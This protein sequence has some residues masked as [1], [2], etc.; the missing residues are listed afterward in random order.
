MSCLRTKCQLTLKNVVDCVGGWLKENPASI[1]AVCVVLSL[2]FTIYVWV[3]ANRLSKPWQRPIL[4]VQGTQ[5]SHKEVD[6]NGD[7]TYS[8]IIKWRNIGR[9]PATDIRTRCWGA[10]LIAPEELQIIGDNNIAN[11]I[12]PEMGWA[13]E[14][15]FKNHGVEPSHINDWSAYFLCVRVDFGDAFEPRRRDHRILYFKYGEKSKNL[16]HATQAEKCRFELY[17]GVAG[18]YDH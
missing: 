1:S 5:C 13:K 3:Q 18:V 10:R 7:V 15:R 8:I 16:A 14:L 11:T 9:H 12:D 4:S 17:L 6:P 2:C